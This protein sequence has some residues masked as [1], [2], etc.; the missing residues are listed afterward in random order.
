MS[1]ESGIA[2]IGLTGQS[3]AGKTT[4][5]KVFEENGFA[6][7]N[8]DKIARE[9]MYKDSPCLKELT[10]CFG[11]EILTDEG[12]LDRHGLGDIVFKN[13]EKLAQLNA[14]SYPYITQEILEKIK[15]Y[16]SMDE[17]FVLLDAPTLF[18]SRADDYCDLIISVTASE[19]IRAARIAQRDG[20]TAEQIK[21][22]FSS[23][24]TEHFFVNHSDFII[25][26]DKSVDLLIEKAHEVADKV[27]EYFTNE[28]TV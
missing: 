28:E 11:E 8:A 22:R 19:K 25:K 7:I 23:Q 21:D 18:E 10:E 2:V 17:K 16:A 1:K 24:H 15:Y 14:I 20:I 13:S 5:C 4:V 12:E 9:V 6:I 26:N 27:K 3:G